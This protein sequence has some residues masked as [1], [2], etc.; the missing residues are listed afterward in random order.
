MS[1]LDGH[2]GARSPRGSALNHRRAHK[3]AK[4]PSAP[5]RREGP[6]K[7]PQDDSVAM[8]QG[9]GGSSSSGLPGTGLHNMRNAHRAGASQK[10]QGAL[11]PETPRRSYDSAPQTA[12]ALTGP[13]RRRWEDLGVTRALHA[14]PEGDP[15]RCGPCGQPERVFLRYKPGSAWIDEVAGPPQGRVR[16]ARPCVRAP[17]RHLSSI[18][19][20]EWSGRGAASSAQILE[21]VGVSIHM[22]ESRG[23]LATT[24]LGDPL[25]AGSRAGR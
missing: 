24:A 20:K 15:A 21:L 16:R 3:L 7:T 10:K 22:S 11:A 2:R 18:L 9:P 13:P 4:I 17:E 1:R 6:E 5:R 19:R 25:A 12:S 23:G 8:G 14:N